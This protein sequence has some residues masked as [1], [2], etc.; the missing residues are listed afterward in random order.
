M[1]HHADRFEAFALRVP[2][3]VE[4]QAHTGG[5]NLPLLAEAQR[6]KTGAGA[7][8]R[9]GYSNGGLDEQADV[10]FLR[11]W[12]EIGCTHVIGDFRDKLAAVKPE[13]VDCHLTGDHLDIRLDTK[14][15]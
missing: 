2:G 10:R 4:G 6:E 14:F 7:G 12:E 11:H 5:V 8:S 3:R 9:V 15:A 1:N 13:Y